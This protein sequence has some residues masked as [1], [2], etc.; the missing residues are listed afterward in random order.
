MDLKKSENK[1]V[2]LSKITELASNISA[3]LKKH[4]RFRSTQGC[5]ALLLAT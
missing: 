2:L 1:G 4:T 3:F 5:L